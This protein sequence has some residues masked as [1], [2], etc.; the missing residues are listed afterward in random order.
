MIL[1]IDVGGTHTDAVL[2]DHF[3]IRKTAKVPT[4][5]DDLLASLQAATTE[6]IDADTV[7]SLERVVLSTTLSTNAIVQNKLARVG[8]LLVSGPG[9]PPSLLDLSGDAHCLA[10]YI[11]HRGIEIAAT[12]ARQAEAL[13]ALFEAEG[14]AHAGIIAKFSPRNPAPE[15]RLKGLIGDRLRHVSLGHQMSGHLNFPRRIATTYL[16]EAVWSIHDRFVAEVLRF[17]Q[18]S[19]IAAPIYIL[20]AD[21]GTFDIRQS[22]DFPVQTILSGPAAS[23]MG[24]LAMTGA[25]EDAIALDIGGTTTDISLFADGVPLF[26]PFG[27]TLAGRKT[28]IRGLRTRS[29]G[30]GGDSMVRVTAGKLAIGPERE[31]PAGALGGPF[32]TPTDAMIVLG[33]TTF[34]ECRGAEA[35]LAPIA[36][37]LNLGVVETAREIFRETCVRIAGHVRAFIDEI[38]NQPV[39][40]IHELLK[41]RSIDPRVLYVV[42][43]PAA[44]VAAELGALLHCEP[45]I[46]P[47]AEVANAIG[48]A[49]ARTTAE[50]TLLAD[51]E[52]RLLT[53]VEEGLQIQ[54]PSQF[55]A[56]DAI[57]IGAEKLRERALRMGAT[58]DEIDI[59][60]VEVQQF[61][62][63]REYATAG[64]NIR[65]KVQIKPGV[66]PG[67]KRG[68]IRC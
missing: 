51:T 6:L 58:E 32:P 28:L 35:A 12:D 46:P 40:T 18:K 67:C 34:G 59:D 24:I 17:A 41:G 26:E 44:S 3:N 14:I 53:V 36:T 16:N 52:Q 5:R 2:I 65:V 55:T 62:M 64:K 19:G 11:N 25:N 10:G 57:R 22:V 47:H 9:L 33:M 54:I 48:A 30:I 4:N 49:L 39:Y 50:I 42:G 37:A 43:G 60:V 21:G 56:A 15:I 8:L 23:I 29:L 38:N 31:G 13:A 68:E 66:I 20:K 1:G 61:N 45:R 27:L 63:V 7:G